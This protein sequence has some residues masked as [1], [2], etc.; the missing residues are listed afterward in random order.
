[1]SSIHPSSPDR[2]AEAQVSGLS[3]IDNDKN[4]KANTPEGLANIAFANVLNATPQNPLNKMSKQQLQ[5][6]LNLAQAADGAI[7]AAATA[8]PKDQRKHIVNAINYLNAVMMEFVQTNMESL[9]VSTKELNENRQAQQKL[10]RDTGTSEGYTV[11]Y[12]KKASSTVMS[13]A[14]MKNTIVQ[15]TRDAKSKLSGLLTQGAQ[16]TQTK[17]SAETQGNDQLMQQASSIINNVLKMTQT[18]Y[19]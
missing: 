8:D 14:Q 13:E 15:A 17:V 10:L 1:M 11:I 7:D 9:G 18:L 16:M 5:H 6:T 19:K 4:K 12:D 2:A 3:N